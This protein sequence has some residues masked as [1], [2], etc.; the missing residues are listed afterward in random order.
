MCS[1]T[2]STI[3]LENLNE[4][5]RKFATEETVGGMLCEICKTSIGR[6]SAIALFSVTA[7]FAL[8]FFVPFL[9]AIPAIGGTLIW[10]FSFALGSVQFAG[11]TF[12][13]VNI[14]ALNRLRARKDPIPFPSV[15]IT[16]QVYLRRI[17][18][19]KERLQG[20]DWGKLQLSD[21]VQKMK[22][23]VE[24][25][26]HAVRLD[27]NDEQTFD[28]GNNFFVGILKEFAQKRVG[29]GECELAHTMGLVN[30]IMLTVFDL[31]NSGT[32]DIALVKY[33]YEV[34]GLVFEVGNGVLGRFDDE[35]GEAEN[36]FANLP[37]Y[38]CG[39]LDAYFHWWDPDP[40]EKI[41]SAEEMQRRVRTLFDRQRR[42]IC[43]HEAK[44][45]LFPTFSI[46]PFV[47]P[48][49]GG[50]SPQKKEEYEKSLSEW[51]KEIESDVETIVQGKTVKIGN[52]NVSFKCFNGEKVVL[53]E[54]KDLSLVTG[55]LKS[56]TPKG[57]TPRKVKEKQPRDSSLFEY[58]QPC[59]GKGGWGYFTIENSDFD[60]V[61]SSV[62]TLA[63]PVYWRS[64]KFSVGVVKAGS[65]RNGI[66]D[67]EVTVLFFRDSDG[68][69]QMARGEVAADGTAKRTHPWFR[70]SIDTMQ[71]DELQIEVLARSLLLAGDNLETRA[72]SARL[73]QE[74]KAKRRNVMRNLSAHVVTP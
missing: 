17:M 33:L 44:E 65:V 27:S 53:I 45:K 8:S 13:G 71:E 32:L 64:V 2:A 31:Q 72:E 54:D 41:R 60:P 4:H 1:A 3:S 30:R 56:F 26:L 16:A 57:T 68:Y 66:Y 29:L 67:V 18:I 25:F 47:L 46:A 74:K 6:W 10:V 20:Y 58:R 73:E 63:V 12:L 36:P 55:D 39:V 22:K 51:E 48:A 61:S 35:F 49:G 15:L 28:L 5:L 59:P 37:P 50:I 7:S 69:L 38:Y 42:D 62:Q 23:M 34:L 11:I 52:G 40:Q 19:A 21:G 14:F 24:D 70:A 9:G 43:R